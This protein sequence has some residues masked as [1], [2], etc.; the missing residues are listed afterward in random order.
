MGLHRLQ[1]TSRAWMA[2]QWC[3]LR[4][5]SADSD[6]LHAAAADPARVAIV[7]AGLMGDTVMSTPVLEAARA[8]WPRARLTLVGQRHNR[9][10]LADAPELD[11]VIESPVLPFALRRRGELRRLRLQIEARRFDVALLILGDQFAAMFARASVPVRVGVRGGMLAPCLTHQYDIG[12]PRSWGPD[13]RLNALRVLGFAVPELRPRL[14]VSPDTARRGETALRALGLGTETAYAVVH[15]FGSTARQWWPV[16][17]LAPLVRHL[18]DRHGLRTVLGGGPET[19]HAAPA[20]LPPGVIDARDRLSI[21]EF[22]AVIAGASLVVSTDS[23]PF[24]IAGALGRPLVGLF[25]ARRPE[26]ANRYANNRVVFGYDPHCDAECE[27]DQCVATPCRQLAALHPDTVAAAVDQAALSG[28][29][30]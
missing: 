23:G 7:I 3:R 6:R 29:L 26:H 8:I 12:T 24:H 11:D 25:R 18:N 5:G 10:L 20:G 14:H 30:A 17:R 16:E 13:E 15:P 2:A 19:R 9:E 22:V 28:R 4:H 21:P 27:W 1:Y